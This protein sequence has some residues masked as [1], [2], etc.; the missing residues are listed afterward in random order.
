MRLS[1]GGAV[2]G[3]GHAPLR[4]GKAAVAM[5]ELVSAVSGAWHATLVL[6]GPRIKPVTIQAG[7]RG[8]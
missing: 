5:S 6:S 4:H 8:L 2:V 1:R 3:L 7:V